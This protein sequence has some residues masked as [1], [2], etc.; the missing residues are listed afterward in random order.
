MGIREFLLPDLGEGLE[1][2]E[3]VGWHVAEGDRVELNQTLV[4]VNTAKALVEIP[5]PWEGVVEKLHASDGDVVKV[6]APL[7]SIRVEDEAERGAEDAEATEAPAETV[8]TE[9]AEEHEAADEARP[10]R[11]AVLVGYGVEEEEEAPAP[12]TADRF[13][14]AEGDGRAGP[15]RASP[16][17][18]RLAK[19]LGIDLAAIDGSGPGGRVT[20]EDV[21]R[22]AEARVP[23]QE[24]AGASA[25]VGPAMGEFEVIPLRGTRRL[26]AEKMTR[27]ARE[28]PHVTTFLTVDATSLQAFREELSAESGTRVS[29]LPIVVRALVQ[30]CR[31]HPSLNASFNAERSQILRYKECHVGVATDTERGLLVPV[32][33]NAERK[34][35][36]ELSREIAQLSEAARSGTIKLLELVGGTITVTNVGTFGAE[37]GTPII[38]HPEA[39]ILALGVVEPRAVVVAGKVEARPTVTLSL[40]FDHRVTDGAEAGRALKALGVLLE[41]PFRLGS[42]PR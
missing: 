30:V 25:G 40:S 38:N 42:L 11:R 24:E 32:I 31:D 27:S 19:E 34:G 21:L 6:G 10:K 13:K 5:A 2:A 12:R 29:P 28:I 26:I 14:P 37:F 7:V 4:E 18:R 20:R 17:V 23:P 1:D 22:V 15:V 35:I 16:P 39:A 41:S 36:L 9:A 8:E 3:I 33:R